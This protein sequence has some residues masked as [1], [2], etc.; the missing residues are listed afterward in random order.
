MGLFSNKNAPTKAGS[1][2]TAWP[3][4][5]GLGLGPYSAEADRQEAYTV[6]TSARRRS[7]PIPAEDAA[8][9]NAALALL[10]QMA[11]EDPLNEVP[12]IQGEVDARLFDEPSGST[13]RATA[14]VTDQR[15]LM[16]WQGVRGRADEMLIAAHQFMIPRPQGQAGLPFMWEEPIAT[17]F[18]IR[19]P[20]TGRQYRRGGVHI[21]PH[22]SSD[23]QANRRAMSVVNTLRE[24]EQRVRVGE[25]I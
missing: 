11:G 20:A 18:P 12:L 22:F 25:A 15:F 1:Y 9:M 23:A 24:V 21:S 19:I 7:E 8:T 14:M 6:Y 13:F 10:Q 17:P 4:S 3:K 5:S 2:K 16:W